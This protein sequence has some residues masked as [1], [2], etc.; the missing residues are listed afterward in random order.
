MTPSAPSFSFSAEKTKQLSPRLSQQ[1]A[2]K[3]RAFGGLVGREVADDVKIITTELAELSTTLAP[4]A[5]EAVSD[6]LHLYFP[7][8]SPDAIFAPCSFS[9]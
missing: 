7:E 9:R 6:H 4:S 1:R 8:R 5:V 2:A 3:K